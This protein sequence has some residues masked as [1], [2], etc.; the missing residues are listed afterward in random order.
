MQRWFSIGVPRATRS[1]MRWV[2]A[3]AAGWALA[4]PAASAAGELQPTPVAGGVYANGP[5]FAIA[6]AGDGSVYVGGDFT[7]ICT[8]ATLCAVRSKIAHISA[9]GRLLAALGGPVTLPAD[10]NAPVRALAISGSDL[11]AGGE[12]TQIGNTPIGGGIAR[13]DG[14]SWHP[15]TGLVGS[16]YAIATAGSDVYAG[17]FFTNEGGKE[18]LRVGRWNGE[19]WFPM[20]LGADGPV[21]ALAVAPSGIYAGGGFDTMIGVDGTRR[22]ARWD[23]ASWQPVGSG[24]GGGAD[25]VHALAVAGNDVYAGGNFTTAGAVQVR[26]LARWDGSAWNA[27]G[28]GPDKQVNALAIAGGDLY[29]G[30][31]FLSLGP[32]LSLRLARWDGAAWHAMA[33]A[34]A[35]VNALAVSPDGLRLWAGGAFTS[36][37]GAAHPFYASFAPADTTPPKLTVEVLPSQ[38]LRRVLPKGLTVT[39][40]CDEAR[41]VTVRASVRGRKVGETTKTLKANTPATVTVKLTPSAQRRLRPALRAPFSVSASAVDNAG[42]HGIATDDVNLRR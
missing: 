42:N 14:A 31:E 9:D 36:V 5:I 2:G 37:G 38:R 23:G 30:G 35:S 41:K 1:W 26:N 13:W 10:T 32:V 39:V 24:M 6:R 40:T 25:E 34:D 28:P 21:F 12:F 16:V 27:L 29:A 20:G 18:L 33:G 8:S 4:G 3:L 19:S 11:Y 17:G 22:I 15:L 7:E